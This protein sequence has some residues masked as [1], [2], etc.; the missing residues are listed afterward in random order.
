MA[1]VVVYE[2]RVSNSVATYGVT[3]CVNDPSIEGVT[4][5][6]VKYPSDLQADIVLGI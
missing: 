6:P 5:E 1:N 3:E 4:I 2:G